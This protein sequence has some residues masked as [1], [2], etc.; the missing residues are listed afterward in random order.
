MRQDSCR[1]VLGFLAR[2]ELQSSMYGSTW[3]L[4]QLV[5]EECVKADP[6]QLTREMVS[7]L[8]L[9]TVSRTIMCYRNCY[10]PRA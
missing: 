8:L 9:K 6:K 1:V 10:T 5:E 4:R 3:T 7:R 2:Y